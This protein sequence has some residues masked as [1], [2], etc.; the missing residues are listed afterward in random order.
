[1]WL[2]QDGEI[3]PILEFNTWLWTARLLGN[4]DAPSL[5]IVLYDFGKVYILYLTFLLSET[6][7]FLNVFFG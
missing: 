4:L 2:C 6:I 7:R 3:P 5:I 1:M